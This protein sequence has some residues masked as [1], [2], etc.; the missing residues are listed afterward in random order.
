MNPQLYRLF[1]EE[2]Q[3]A[4]IAVDLKTG[5]VVA[6][7]RTFEALTGFSNDEILGE[8]INLVSSNL[9]S[10][11][12]R[13]RKFDLETLSTPGLYNDLVLATKDQDVRFVSTKVRHLVLDGANLAMAV[14]SDDTERQFLIRDLAAKHQGLEQT[15]S[16]LEKVHEELKTSQERMSQSSKLAALGELSAGLSHELGQPLTGVKGFAQEGLDILKTEAKPS[17]KKMRE[18]LSEIVLNADKMASLLAHFRSFARQEKKSFEARDEKLEPV[19][20]AKIYQ[21][22]TKLMK[23]QFENHGIAII[24]EDSGSARDLAAANA[25]PIEQVLINLLSNS[26]DALI[27]KSKTNKNFRPHV[28]VQVTQ[29]LTYCYL[30]VSDNGPGISELYKSKIFDPFFTTKELGK[31][32]GLG[33]SISYGIAHRFQGDIK[34]DRSDKNGSSFTLKIPRYVAGVGA[35]E[36]ALTA[37]PVL[38]KKVAA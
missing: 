12:A 34:L 3:D 11:Y 6:L 37:V 23:R 19:S 30:T 10:E 38:P 24:F 27:D 26:R 8:S 14:L 32:T 21:S 31:G 35:D 29:D 7:N 9:N 1:F 15:F 17:K 5:K 36:G 18:L 2:S 28:K 16:E 13:E 4:H 20:F 25:H 22:V 33:L